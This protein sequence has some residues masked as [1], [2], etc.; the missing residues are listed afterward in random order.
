MKIENTEYKR[1]QNIQNTLLYAP[2]LG[3][4][5][6]EAACPGHK[7]KSLRNPFEWQKERVRSGHVS[8]Y[9]L[10]LSRMLS[11]SL[12]GGKLAVPT[13][14]SLLQ[15][16]DANSPATEKLRESLKNGEN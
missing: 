12:L 5:Y 11:R 9:P 4:K 2:L 6:Y 3:G 10:L 1:T 14:P 7:L 13:Q 15:A 8:V 16:Q